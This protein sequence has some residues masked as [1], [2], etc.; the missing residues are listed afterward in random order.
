MA[1]YLATLL[2]HFQNKIDF[3]NECR[4]KVRTQANS[5]RVSLLIF[6]PLSR[7]FPLLAT[8]QLS[9]I[10]PLWRKY[11]SILTSFARIL[12]LFNKIKQGQRRQLKVLK[13]NEY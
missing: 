6:E 7:K 13:I 2:F 9:L 1:T 5:S 11:L 12:C 3:E 4:L 8:T 10:M